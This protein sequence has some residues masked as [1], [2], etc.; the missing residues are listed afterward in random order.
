MEGDD[1]IKRL[2]VVLAF[3]SAA[4]LSGCAAV[5]QDI[6]MSRQADVEAGNYTMRVD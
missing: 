1:K 6:H 2:S 3:I 4:F 5:P